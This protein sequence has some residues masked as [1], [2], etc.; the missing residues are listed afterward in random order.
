VLCNCV[1]VHFLTKRNLERKIR[2]QAELPQTTAELERKMPIDFY[3]SLV[4]PACRPVMLVARALSVELNLRK[5]SMKDNEN[6]TPEFLK[7][8]SAHR[9]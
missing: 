8:S 9:K 7:V 6:K 5:I 1:P 4:S 2:S 3:Y